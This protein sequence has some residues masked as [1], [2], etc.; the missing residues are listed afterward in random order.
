MKKNQ[1]T[2]A[3]TANTELVSIVM[4]S[5]SM[6]AAGRIAYFHNLSKQA[7]KV[8]IK[9]ALF[10]GLELM[11]VKA[12]LPHGEYQNWIVANCPFKYS[13]AHNYIAIA[14]HLI[15]REESMEELANETEKTRIAA[16][17]EASEACEDKNLM[18]L[19]VDLGIVKKAKSNLGGKREGAGRK[20]NEEKAR[21]A[22]AAEAAAHDGDLAA[23]TVEGLL[24]D[25]YRVLVID[26]A[27]G[28]LETDKLEGVSKSL[29][30]LYK[31][32]VEAVGNRHSQLLKKKL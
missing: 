30:N 29:E 22:L 17:N 1:V 10:A 28:D 24:A 16:V 31:K 14:H 20:S 23:K 2:V 26:G 11:R 21:L 32:S 12:S 3:N 15:D 9:A 5:P 4:P 8:S 18:E 27:L 25:L 13:T 19:Y 6:D 7:G